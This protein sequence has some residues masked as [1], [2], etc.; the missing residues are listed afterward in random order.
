MQSARLVG[1]RGR[2]APAKAAIPLKIT[3]SF[4]L[5]NL[6]SLQY[7]NV[8]IADDDQTIHE[9]YKEILRPVDDSPSTKVRS[10][11]VMV[12]APKD[13]YNFNVIHAFNGKEALEHAKRQEGHHLPV[14]MA[15]IDLQMPEWD[16]FETIKQINEFDPRISFIIVTGY[17]EQARREISDRLGAMPVKIIEKPFVLQD[18][19]DTVYSL[20]VR[21]NRI[22]AD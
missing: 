19:Y 22:H 9:I 5:K 15:V 14:Q 13:I 1:V 16:G 2:R 11:E 12:D 20:V 3:M 17:A 21:W 10:G 18:L 8:L 7:R 6:T 4:K